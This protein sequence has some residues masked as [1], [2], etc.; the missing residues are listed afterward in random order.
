MKSEARHPT[1]PA[2]RSGFRHTSTPRAVTNCSWPAPSLCSAACRYLRHLAASPERV[3]ALLQIATLAWNRVPAG[4]AYG[5]G[6]LAITLARPVFDPR[7][8]RPP[9][10]PMPWEYIRPPEHRVHPVPIAYVGNDIEGNLAALYCQDRGIKGAFWANFL[11][12]SHVELAGGE[13][14]LKRQLNGM[15]IERSRMAACLS[16]RP[17]RRCR[18]IPKTHAP[19]SCARRGAQARVPVAGRHP[20]DEARHARVFYRERPPLG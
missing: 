10:A 1:S 18:K 17:T 15:R 12:A 8:P 20:R 16:L 6:S 11:S 7:M 3:E 4:P 19:D 13:A 2:R 9:G 5:Y 14:A